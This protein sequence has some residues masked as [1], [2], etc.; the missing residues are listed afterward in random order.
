[1]STLFICHV[2]VCGA[3]PSVPQKNPRIPLYLGS[4]VLA[5]AL[6]RYGL[7][8]YDA[9]EFK[10]SRVMRLYHVIVYY[11]AEIIWNHVIVHSFTIHSI[12]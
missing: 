1:M 10:V 9:L 4:K 6:P 7:L 8:I 2:S 3:H 12:A 11:G 5:T